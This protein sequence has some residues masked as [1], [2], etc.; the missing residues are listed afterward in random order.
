MRAYD[1]S[2]AFDISTNHDVVV[3]ELRGWD[4]AM[5]GR[6]R[7]EFEPA[8]ITSVSVADRAALEPLIDHRALGCGTHNGSKRPGGRRIGTMLGRGVPGKQFWAVRAGPSTSRLVVLHLV[9]HEFQ[10]AVIEV[11]DPDELRTVV[12]KAIDRR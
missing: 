8:T 2:V 10:R 6:R 1:A 5:N 7:V 4:R 11:D 3:V 9:G 12:E